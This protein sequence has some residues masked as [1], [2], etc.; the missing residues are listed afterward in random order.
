[1]NPRNSLIQVSI[2]CV[3][4]ALIASTVKIDDPGTWPHNIP[5]VSLLFVIGG[6]AWTV[7]SAFISIENRLKA[8]EEGNK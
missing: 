2:G 5:I 8:L 3:L 1:M 7:R 4:L 6:L